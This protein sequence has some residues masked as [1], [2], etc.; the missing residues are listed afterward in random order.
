V[1]E[2]PRGILFH[3]YVYE[4]GHC[5]KAKCIIP[6][7]QNLGNIDRDLRALTPQLMETYYPDKDTIRHKLEMLI[8]SYDPCISCSVHLLEVEFKE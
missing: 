2:A 5:V 1:V 6:T 4:K 7:A 3:N 8:R